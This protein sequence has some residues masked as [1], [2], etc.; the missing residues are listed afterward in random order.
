MPYAV[1]VGLI[2]GSWSTLFM[3]WDTRPWHLEV[4]WQTM[5]RGRMPNAVRKVEACPPVPDPV[6]KVAT[7]LGAWV[8]GDSGGLMR[9][10]G[11]D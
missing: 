2:Q 4:E 3:W 9:R 5:G 7:N 6:P 1:L 11:S 8:K 10:V